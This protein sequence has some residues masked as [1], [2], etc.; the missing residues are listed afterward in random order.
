MYIDLGP[1]MLSLHKNNSVDDNDGVK[2]DSVNDNDNDG[3]T[4][5]NMNDNGNDDND[6]NK[7]ND[8]DNDDVDCC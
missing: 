3:V 1:S 6:N 8:D 2:D 5:D 4:D 7:Y